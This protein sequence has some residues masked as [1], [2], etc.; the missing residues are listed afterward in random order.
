M[1]IPGGIFFFTA[2]FFYYHLYGRLEG[3]S[4]HAPIEGECWYNSRTN[5]LPEHC[6]TRFSKRN[7]CIFSH[8]WS[9]FNQSVSIFSGCRFSANHILGS[10]GGKNSEKMGTGKKIPALVRRLPWGVWKAEQH[11]SILELPLLLQNKKWTKREHFKKKGGCYFKNS[12]AYL[13][14]Q[15]SSLYFIA[16][17]QGYFKCEFGNV[18]SDAPE[19]HG[20]FSMMHSF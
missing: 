18:F 12:S 20:Y 2:P 11:L 13:W 8:Q 16:W 10:K 5:S 17:S 9:S 7:W 19:H 6:E 3:R 14:H 4:P 15:K 1:V